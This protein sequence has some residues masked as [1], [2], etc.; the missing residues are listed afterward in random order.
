MIGYIIKRL[1]Q[2]VLV[3]FVVA[4]MV[5]IVVR[6]AGNPL[7]LLLPPDATQAQVEAM[8]IRLGLHRPV[9]QQFFFF[10]LGAIQGDLGVSY[11]FGEPALELV[12]RRVPATLQLASFAMGLALIIS[13]P[14]G[15]L[16]AVKRG[17]LLDRMSLL[18]SL[19]GISAPTFWVGILFI[20]IFAVQL[21]WLP[22]Y[23]Y[24]TFRH[25]I[26][27]G[28]TLSLYYLAL[29]IR[30][31]RAGMLDVIKQDYI[32]T[33]RA[34]GLGE[35]V[36]IYKHALKNTMIPFVTICGLQLGG[37]IA[38]SIVTE[39]IFAWPGMGRLLL[40]AIEQLD[41]PVIISY[42]LL[43][44]FIFGFLNLFVDLMYAF[45]DPRIRYH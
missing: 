14:V 12:L 31:N 34:K 4:L 28:T 8:E 32:R 13:I 41:Y 19:F 30:L 37:L 7:Q 45:L 9:Y 39:K 17:G 38:F 29:F 18:L 36:V 3:L 40:Q 35:K 43:T 15:S 26:L 16:S 6:L 33:A 2:L 23:G 11:F 22:S 20:Y 21:G 25:L 5:F 27:P 42:T 44:A 24:G 10:L 1:L